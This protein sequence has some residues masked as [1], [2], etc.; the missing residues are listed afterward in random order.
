MDHRRRRSADSGGPEG[1]KK[2]IALIFIFFDSLQEGINL[3]IGAIKGIHHWVAALVGGAL[4]WGYRSADQC[5][6]YLY[7]NLLKFC[8]KTDSPFVR[9]VKKRYLTCDLI[10]TPMARYGN[11]GKLNEKLKIV[12][13]SRRYRGIFNVPHL[14]FFVK[15]TN[16]GVKMVNIKEIEKMQIEKEKSN[17]QLAEA[18]GISVQALWK[19]K[20]GIIQ[21]SLEDVRTICDFLDIR[22]PAHKAEIFLS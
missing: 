14:K 16:G 3:L 6:G 18:L 11:I 13:K 5:G 8:H 2:I 10:V 19:K 20:K 12:S 17:R 1:D 22:E 9:T 21:W 4:V 7:C 15:I